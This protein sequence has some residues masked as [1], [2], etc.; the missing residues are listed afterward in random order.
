[1]IENKNLILIVDDN[2]DTCLLIKTILELNGYKVEI[3]HNG[4]E[5]LEYVKEKTVA[6]ILLDIMMPEMNGIEV[7]DIL[8]KN[9]NY[10]NIPIIAI[11]AKNDEPFI[12]EIFEK[13]VD[14]YIEKPF[15]NFELL[16]RVKSVISKI[17]KE[18]KEYNNKKEISV[19][20]ED[21][22]TKLKKIYKLQETFITCIIH[23][24]K[25]PITSIRSLSELLLTNEKIPKEKVNEFLKNILKQS[26]N[27][28]EMI[29]EIGS[30]L[31]NNLEEIKLNLELI[32]LSDIIEFIN[33]TF[34]SQAE[35]K[36]IGFEIINNAS[37]DKIYCDFIRIKELFLN[38]IS[39]AFKFTIKGSISLEINNDEKN[40][41]FDIIDTGI[42]IFETDLSKIFEKFYRGINGIT[43][44][45]WG[46]GL[47]ISLKIAYAHGGNI[48]VTSEQN[49]G[50]TFR[51]VIPLEI[52]DSNLQ[53]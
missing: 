14:D 11:T 42:G 29:N 12:K 25:T 45:G 13:G 44:E 37:I 34:L 50:S 8:K 31:K 51:V 18:N 15:K 9:N 49:K 3:R 46:I 28:T 33:S 2:K 39:N 20:V 48:I 6:L 52:K 41:Y 10:K 5:C 36:K 32:N 22:L 26:D 24:L 16:A 35:L 40:I 38:L 17:Y 4:K 7:L 21:Q 1:M 19:T 27:L 30:I 43:K 23:D 53:F 47:Y